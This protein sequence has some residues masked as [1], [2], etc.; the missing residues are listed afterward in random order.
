[1]SIKDFF[2]NVIEILELGTILEEPKQITG[3]LTHRM[4]KIVTTKGKYIVKLLNPNIMK[5]PTAMTNFKNAD[6]L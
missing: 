6:T 5:R 3:G 4:F 1:M 2:K